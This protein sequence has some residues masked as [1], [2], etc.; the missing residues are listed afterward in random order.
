VTNNN[1]QLLHVHWQVL[2]VLDPDQATAPLPNECPDGVTP[3][4]RKARARHFRP[5]ITLPPNHMQEACN[6]VIEML[7]GR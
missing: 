3:P 7:A 5:P 4:M 1:K 6:D 2:V